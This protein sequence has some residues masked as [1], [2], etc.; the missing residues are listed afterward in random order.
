MTEVWGAVEGLAIWVSG[1]LVAA[2][3]WVTRNVLT[4]GKQIAML[5]Q[6]IKHQD[7]QREEVK[8]SVRVI[9]A[10]VGE[11]RKFLLEKK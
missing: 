3:L 7:G 9:R 5:E 1:L 2:V 10:E 6:Q 4:N 11:I 8:E